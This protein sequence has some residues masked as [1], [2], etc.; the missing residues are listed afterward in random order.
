MI[1]SASMR[2]NVI[3]IAI[4]PA[5]SDRRLFETN[6]MALADSE[7]R[8]H[9]RRHVLDLGVDFTEEGLRVC[10]CIE[11]KHLRHLVRMPFE[12]MDGVGW[13]VEKIT[14]TE[15]ARYAVDQET[16]FTGNDVIGLVP[17]M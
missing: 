6:L 1:R 8:S 13:R 2:F 4:I 14:C 10:R 17:W 11:Y 15:Q 3:C 7:H 12:C 9:I 5:H 16:D